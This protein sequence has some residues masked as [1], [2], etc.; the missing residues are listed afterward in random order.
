MTTRLFYSTVIIHAVLAV[1]AHYAVKKD[2]VKKD[3]SPQSVEINVKL[4]KD[5]SKSKAETKGHAESPA[6]ASV[7]E[8]S[9]QKT[10]R[11]K[12]PVAGGRRLC[13]TEDATGFR[14]RAAP[15]KRN[16]DSDSLQ[17]KWYWTGSNIKNL[18]SPGRCMGLKV[19]GENPF[20]SGHDQSHD[21][22]AVH[23]LSMAFDCAHSDAHQ[24]LDWMLDE[25]GRLM[26][27][28]NHQCMAI[29]EQQSA[30]Y[31][32]MVQPCDG[33]ES[34]AEGAT[35]P[36]ESKTAAKKS[37]L[38]QLQD[39][40][41]VRLAEDAAAAARKQ[42]LEAKKPDAN[43][44]VAKTPEEHKKVLAAAAKE[45]GAKKHGDKKH[46]AKKPEEHKKVL[47]AAA[48]KPA[49]K[50]HVAKKETALAA[51]AKKTPN[52]NKLDAEKLAAKVPGKHKKVLAAAAKKVASKPIAK[53]PVAKRAA[54]K[55]PPVPRQKVLAASGKK[56]AS[57]PIAKKSVAKRAA[58][59]K[60]PVARQRSNKAK[61]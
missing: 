35:K 47:A 17:Q 14:V 41:K 25:S 8:K 40:Q 46:V 37:K 2:A 58:A 52:A 36:D 55:K 60:P 5:E 50:K 38:E 29:N 21:E 61:R 45:S 19:E 44:T 33:G 3:P 11:I 10:F 31:H 30:N 18:F 32:A 12:L 28:H 20:E 57:K 9:E 51:A 6:A 59:K 48:K 56:V 54:A 13:L 15:C 23:H 22:A 53:K 49:D 34:L 43:K 7:M 39:Y 1:T 24:S 42:K 4:S 16:D 26:S 27:K